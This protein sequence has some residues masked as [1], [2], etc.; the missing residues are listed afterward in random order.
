MFKMLIRMFEKQQE[1]QEKLGI[2]KKIEADPPQAK[3]AFINQMILACQEEL[4][5][6]MR[7]TPYKN[8]EYVPFGWK[9]GQIGD[10][11]KFKD[12]IIDLWH[13]VMNL[14]L[15]SGM[16]ANEFYLRYCKKN[17]INLHRQKI[18]Y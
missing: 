1:L 12:E 7:E 16:N 2:W 8:P 18:N 17:T 10:P 6:I 13:F 14:A 9:K 5:E 3:Q 15:V 11:E 4:V